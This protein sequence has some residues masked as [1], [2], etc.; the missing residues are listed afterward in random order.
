MW[1]EEAM[2]EFKMLHRYFSGETEENHED[3]SQDSQSSSQHLTLEL[4]ERIAEVL[5]TKAR[6]LVILETQ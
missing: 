3:N 5:T 4:S 6:C 1:K 2:T